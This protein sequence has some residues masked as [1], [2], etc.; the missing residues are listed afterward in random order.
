MQ[1]NIESTVKQDK[2][3]QVYLIIKFIFNTWTFYISAKFDFP[4]V[5]LKLMN[6]QYMTKKEKDKL[7]KKQ[8]KLDHCLELLEIEE[9]EFLHL[10]RDDPSKVI[11]KHTKKF[12]TDVIM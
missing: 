3:K 7:K 11:S 10:M 2:G 12:V 1:T 4:T 5:P 6:T 8:E 9:K